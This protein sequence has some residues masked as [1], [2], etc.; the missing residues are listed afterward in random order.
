VLP[1]YCHLSR[2]S[3][4]VAPGQTSRPAAGYAVSVGDDLPSCKRQAA[5]SSPAL[6]QTQ[7][8]R[9]TQ[10][11]VGQVAPR[12]IEENLL[13]RWGPCLRL[14]RRPTSWPTDGVAPKA[15]SGRRH[16][17]RGSTSYFEM[18]SKSLRSG[19][20]WTLP[21]RCS[22]KRGATTSAAASALACESHSTKIP[23]WPSLSSPNTVTPPQPGCD[24]INGAMRQVP[25]PQSAFRARMRISPDGLSLVEP[26]RFQVARSPG[27]GA[28][29]GLVGW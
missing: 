21:M 15:A 20:P 19:E 6:V 12:K 23:Y 1:P 3:D 24:A 7:T 8:V 28:P 11:R 17:V 29:A 4:L 16:R 9:R 25:G 26:P 5:A 18:T 2:A 22:S 14:D 13:R 27:V 10:S